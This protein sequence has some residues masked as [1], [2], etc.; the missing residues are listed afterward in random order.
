VIAVGTTMPVLSGIT[1]PFELSSLAP[2]ISAARNGQSDLGTLGSL[3]T[4][5]AIPYARLS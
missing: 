2:K 5:S 1:P 4:T 3:G